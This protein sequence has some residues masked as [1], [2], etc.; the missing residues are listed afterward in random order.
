M[1]AELQLVASAFNREGISETGPFADLGAVNGKVRLPRSN[2]IMGAAGY[3]RC[4]LEC[5]RL[6][7]GRL[8]REDAI[9]EVAFDFHAIDSP[10]TPA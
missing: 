10:I 4:A 6:E 5:H 9:Y 2:H 3:L 8:E 7:G 1:P